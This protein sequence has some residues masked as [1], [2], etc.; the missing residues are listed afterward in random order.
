MKNFIKWAEENKIELPVYIEPTNE[1]SD[2][3]R[4]SHWSYEEEDSLKHIPKENKE[5]NN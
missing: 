1:N 5:E 2:E 3:N 4:I